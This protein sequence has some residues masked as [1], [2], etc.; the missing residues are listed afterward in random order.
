MINGKNND[1]HPLAFVA[2][3]LGP[4]PDILS[5]RESMA[6]LNKLD[7]EESMNEGMI[8]CFDNDIYEIVKRPSV[9]KPKILLRDV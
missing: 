2:Q 9:S 5:H 1:R 3:G 4:S 6:A 7:F 8:K